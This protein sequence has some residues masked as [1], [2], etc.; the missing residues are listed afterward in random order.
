MTSRTPNTDAIGLMD[1]T[2]R[3][4]GHTV[5]EGFS[6]RVP[7]GEKVTLA[8]PSGSG[9]TSILRSLLGF[10]TPE[11]GTVSVAGE[12]VT[13]QSV[14]GIRSRLAYVPQEAD[15]GEGTVRT[16]LRR[17]FEY[18]ANAGLHLD[19]GLLSEMF[20]R[21]RLPMR[22]LDKDISDLS[23]GEKQRVAIVC[24]I[25]LQREIVL[26]D[27]AASA[28]DRDNAV[29]V[30]EY[31]REQEELTVLSCAHDALSLPLPGRVVSLLEGDAR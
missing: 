30:A 17:P 1:V 23:G 5:L 22:F 9:K 20:D 3:F 28:L 15:P 27:E 16:I 11:R 25:L 21:F 8:G 26:L 24:A 7:T 31:F 18:R 29:A 10:L 14:W 4:H 6:L 2:L 13:S 12:P 19:D